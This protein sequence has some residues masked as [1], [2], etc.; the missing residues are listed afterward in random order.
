[1]MVLTDKRKMERSMVVLKGGQKLKDLE[2]VFYSFFV[3]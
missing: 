1:M 3:P 2:N